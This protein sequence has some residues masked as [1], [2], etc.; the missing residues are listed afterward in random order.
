M[1]LIY[2]NADGLISKK[3]ELVNLLNERNPDIVCVTETKL[4][5]DDNFILKGYDVW[6]K[7]RADGRG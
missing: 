5:P 1:R 2:T 4:S 3:L 6:R 7:G